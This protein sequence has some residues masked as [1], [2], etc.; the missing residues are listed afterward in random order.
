MDMRLSP[1]DRYNPAARKV[2]AAR[3]QAIASAATAGSDSGGSAEKV[4]AHHEAEQAAPDTAATS[5]LDAS[6]AATDTV[7]KVRGLD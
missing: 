4:D 6:G 7:G 1:G 3:V 5:S 2:S